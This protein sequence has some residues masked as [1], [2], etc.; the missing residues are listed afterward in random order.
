MKNPT[1]GLDSR[2]GDSTFIPVGGPHGH[3]SEHPEIRHAIGC[4]IN[5][6]RI[7]MALALVP[8]AAIACGAALGLP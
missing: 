2:D 5:L 3:P 6:G 4:R 8:F 1:E 7:G